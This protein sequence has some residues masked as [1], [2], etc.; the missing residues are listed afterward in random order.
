MP[1]SE[2]DL[3]ALS[4]YL[5]GELDEATAHRMETRISLDPALRAE[6][7]S[8]RQ[9]WGLLDYLP[10]ATPRPDFTNRTLERLSVERRVALGNGLWRRLRPVVGW[11][12]AAVLVACIGYVSGGRMHS[13]PPEP[14]E[15]ESDDV[16]VQHLPV[17]ERWS[18]YQHASDLDF[19][20][21]LDDPE[22]FGEEPG[23]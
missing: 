18:L 4:A 3:A 1:L 22:L 15:P 5:D 12:A 2:E 23:Q 8:L 14:P 7:E 20:R 17:I 6:Y 11:T 19:V 21:G 16:L 9:T 10:R 13:R